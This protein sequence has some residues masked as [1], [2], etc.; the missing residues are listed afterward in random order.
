MESNFINKFK[1]IISI[2]IENNIYLFFWGEEGG[3]VRS[4]EH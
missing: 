4:F 3:C 1:N 2:L